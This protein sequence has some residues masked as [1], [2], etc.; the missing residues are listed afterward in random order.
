[1][2]P[3]LLPRLSECALGAYHGTERG[4]CQFC[5]FSFVSVGNEADT[6]FADFIVDVIMKLSRLVAD[7]GE[8]IEEIDINPLVVSAKGAKVVDALIVKK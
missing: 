3:Q 4:I 2:T 7:M 5:I 6:E 1:M 8:K